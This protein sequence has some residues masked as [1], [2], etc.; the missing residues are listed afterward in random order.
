M[1]MTPILQKIAHPGSLLIESLNRSLKPRVTSQTHP[2]IA[3]V[4]EDVFMYVIFFHPRNTMLYDYLT[5]VRGRNPPPEPALP[6]DI[7][8]CI[9]DEVVKESDSDTLVTCNSV[10]RT[11]LDASRRRLFAE[12]YIS[13]PEECKAVLTILLGKF[14]IASYIKTLRVVDNPG[15]DEGWS[16]PNTSL[17]RVLNIL[18]TS[19]RLHT[20][21]FTIHS[22][23]VW[24]PQAADPRNSILGLCAPEP[25]QPRRLSMAPLRK[26]LKRVSLNLRSDAARADPAIERQTKTGVLHTLEIGGPDAQ[27]AV[28]FLKGSFCALDITQLRELIRC[29]ED[30]GSVAAAEDVRKTAEATLE[31]MGER[32]DPTV[33]RISQTVVLPDGREFTLTLT[34]STL[35]S[36]FQILSLGALTQ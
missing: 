13:S 20:L 17:P 33:H 4:E 28:D 15:P 30:E 25:P 11:F 16:I 24:R 1:I 21:S 14:T 32:P 8:N 3:Q 2:I 31:L 27:R 23:I 35:I 10:S 18:G 19:G 6:F 12:T 22:S 36:N 5:H 29:G 34:S 7:I 26:A 9:L